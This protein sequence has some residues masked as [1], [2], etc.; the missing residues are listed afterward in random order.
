M[1]FNKDNWL[2]GLKKAVQ[3]LKAQ[4]TAGLPCAVAVCRHIRD[5]MLEEVSEDDKA[6]VNDFFNGEDGFIRAIANAEAKGDLCGFACNA[7]AAAK[8]AKIES[9]T[10]SAVDILD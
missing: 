8:A 7:S 6:I 2:A 5:A 3:D 1:T 10:K 9:A 4:P